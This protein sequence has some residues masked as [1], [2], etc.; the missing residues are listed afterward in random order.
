MNRI[1]KSFV[2]LFALTALIT[3][4]NDSGSGD[5]G[6]LT[7]AF[8]KEVAFST[9]AGS[10]GGI[11]SERMMNLYLAGDIKGSGIINSVS[12]KH[13]NTVASA[14]TCSSFTMKMGHTN[15]S[16]LVTTYADNVEQGQGSFQTVRNGSITMPAGAAGSYFTV[17]LSQP[18][19][20][21]GVDNLVVDVAYSGCSGPVAQ[22]RSHQVSYNGEL[23]AAN[24]AAL[25]GTLYDYV[26]D[27]KFN[28][29]GGDN[30]ISSTPVTYDNYPF[31]LSQ[32][33]QLLYTAAE[34]NGSGLITGIGF[35]MTHLAVPYSATVTV[36]LGHTSLTGLPTAPD[37]TFAVNFNSGTPVTMANARTFTI[38]AGTPDGAYVW[39]PLPDGAFSY[40]GTDNLIVEIETSAITGSVGWV[41]DS[42]TRTRMYGDYGALTGNT[43]DE[44]YFIKFRFAGGPIDVITAG[45]SAVTIPFANWSS[46]GS[47]SQMLYK[48]AE[49][50][51]KGTITKVA[52]RLDGPASAGTYDTLTIRL[53]NTA[54]TTLSSTFSTN[55]PSATTVYTGTY[56][57]PGGTLKAGD[58]IEI[59]LSTPFVID[60]TRNLLVQISNHA[61]DANNQIRGSLNAT[62]YPG[63]YNN[64]LDYTTANGSVVDF[65]AD[66]RLIMQ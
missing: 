18:F 41:C 31:A 40:N 28:F 33:V 23:E 60:P 59:P 61:G 50:G 44:H 63:R 8:T 58:W 4:C 5:S 10:W 2:L 48:S 14:A 16:N 6:T 54:L 43:D 35:P 25:T 47:I 26:T 7:V 49:L 46:G 30:A 21:N 13:A 12:I 9:T 3:G 64:A 45:A 32:K 36:K 24:S 22:V 52:Y 53:A 57:I 62:R 11:A 55:M 37:S 20:Y 42:G 15:V 29:A 56:L 1:T 65:L 39:I 66:L 27:V 19:N 34:I 17:N 38:P 51:A